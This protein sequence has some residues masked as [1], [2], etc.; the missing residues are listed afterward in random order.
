MCKQIED[1]N[2]IVADAVQKQSSEELIFKS[3]FTFVRG[4]IDKIGSVHKGVS[5]KIYLKT[6]EDFSSPEAHEML[7]VFTRLLFTSLTASLR[8][9]FIYLI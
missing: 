9:R 7:H 3:Y 2:A 4:I 1:C 6:E 5:I 8:C